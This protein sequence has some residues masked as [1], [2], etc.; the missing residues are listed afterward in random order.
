MRDAVEG[1]VRYV[2][3]GIRT[4]FDLGRGNGPINHFHSLSV[5]RAPAPFP[6]TLKRSI[7]SKRMVDDLAMGRIVQG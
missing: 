5:T 2:E 6:S 3:L 7:Y 4:G 1:A